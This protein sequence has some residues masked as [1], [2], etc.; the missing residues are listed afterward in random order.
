M[1]GTIFD[2]KEFSVHDGPG[3]RTTVFLKGC[4]LRCKWCHNPEGLSPYPQIM[5]KEN[6]CTHCKRCFNPCGHEIC[7]KYGRCLFACPLGLISLTGKEMDSA[8]VAAKILRGKDF[9]R[10]SGGGV[11]ISGGEPLMQHEFTLDLLKRTSELHRAI[12][13][14]GFASNKVFSDVIANTDYVMMDLKLIDPVMHKEYTGVDNTVILENAEILKKSGKAHVFRVP[15]IPDITDTEENLRAISEI[16]GDSPVE[17]LPYNV[18]AGAKYKSVG[19]TYP[20]E[21]H[22][23]ENNKIDI[24]IFKRGKLL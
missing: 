21:G 5:V 7:K 15:L 3:V 6:Q 11:T 4:P 24:S 18:M 17:L 12:Q 8:D 20:L 2:I 19:L 1:L 9:M 23:T 13:T 16:A 10:M 22:K 14:S